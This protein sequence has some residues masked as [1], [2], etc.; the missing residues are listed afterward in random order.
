M[1]LALLLSPSVAATLVTVTLTELYRTSGGGC[2]P[3]GTVEFGANKTLDKVVFAPVIAHHHSGSN[4]LAF[5]LFRNGTEVYST[6]WS[7]SAVAQAPVEYERSLNRTLADR[8]AFNGY[9]GSRS[10][11]FAYL[12][13]RMV[14]ILLTAR[15][16][17]EDEPENLGLISDLVDPAPGSTHFRVA[18]TTPNTLVWAGY[19]TDYTKKLTTDPDGDEAVW[20]CI[21]T[22]GNSLCDVNENAAR[23]CWDAGF[24]W[25]QGKCCGRDYAGC[26]FVGAIQN[27]TMRVCTPAPRERPGGRETCVNVPTFANINSTCGRNAAGEWEW[28]PLSEPGEIHEFFGCAENSSLVSDGKKVWQ[29]GSGTLFGDASAMNVF[30]GVNLSGETHEYF[31]ENKTITECGGRQAFASINT[32]ETGDV[33]VFNTSSLQYCASD[34]DWTTDLD[35]KD[36]D[37]CEA[38]GFFWTGSMCC[39]ENDDRGEYYNDPLALTATAGRGGCWNKTYVESGR[40][41][42]Q[43]KVINY[44]GKFFGCR[45]NTTVLLLKDSHTDET[46]INNSLGVCGEVLNNAVPGHQY[47]HAVCNPQGVW[48][49]TKELMGEL[50][51]TIKWS[52]LINM[53]GIRQAGCCAFDQCWNGTRCQPLDAFYRINDRGFVCNLP[54]AAPQ[55]IPVFGEPVCS[56]DAQGNRVC[57]A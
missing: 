29:C 2:C 42:V 14:P 55:E 9:L 20:A 31:C 36:E 16:S 48:E 41:A 17:P 26:Q 49:F 51:K 46:L 32:R 56:T 12:E 57:I 43:N 5:T 40:F 44:R 39:S 22:N 6:S 8:F 3:G 21:D 38:A 34:G 28:A 47:P 18:T 10:S 30:A 13:A 11:G 23:T 37:S 54:S 4:S 35:V 50:Q 1:I 52:A 24:D 15:L 53:S 25:Y 33:K 19:D 45:L 27:G 7:L